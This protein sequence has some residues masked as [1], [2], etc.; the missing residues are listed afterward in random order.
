MQNGLRTTL[1]HLAW[2]LAPMQM[3]ERYLAHDKFAERE[4]DIIGDIVDP[5]RGS[6]DVGANLGRYT[7]LLSKHTDF[8]IAFE[9]HPEVA[10]LLRDLVRR[11]GIDNVTIIEKAASSTADKARPFFLPPE[12]TGHSTLE[13]TAQTGSTDVTEVITATLDQLANQNVGFVKIDVEGHEYDVLCGAKQFIAANSPTFLIEIE[14]FIAPGQIAI[15]RE[16]FDERN[17]AG[18]YIYKNG[19][20][21]IDAF[22]S[23][24]QD[25]KALDWSRSRREM[26]F[27]NNFLFAPK[28]TAAEQM[29]QRVAKGL[30]RAIS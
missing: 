5:T 11:K 2:K 30:T 6:I 4:E 19:L 18:Y 26:D 23:R 14:T 21:P 10:R 22:D 1:S 20:H 27:V 9:P 25:R 17:Y 28:G 29:A 24:L 15:I 8:V 7:V 16:F 3:H 13:Q 12:G